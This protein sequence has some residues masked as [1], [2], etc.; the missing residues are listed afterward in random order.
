MW[1]TNIVLIK[2]LLKDCNRLPTFRLSVIKTIIK[3]FNTFQADMEKETSEL[4]IKLKF[5]ELFR[6][7][8]KNNAWKWKLRFK[9]FF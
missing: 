5:C 3:N 4:T 2:E 6:I 9:I 7:S 8:L 1:K